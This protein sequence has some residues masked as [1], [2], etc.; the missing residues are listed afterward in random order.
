[1]LFYIGEIIDIISNSNSYGVPVGRYRINDLY[2]CNVHQSGNAY[3]IE[4]VNDFLKWSFAF[5]N[6]EE[7]VFWRKESSV[8]QPVNVN[9]APIQIDTYALEQ[10]MNRIIEELDKKQDKRV[11]ESTPKLPEKVIIDSSDIDMN[12]LL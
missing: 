11:E 10:T 3:E 6:H 8:S 9:V 2:G 5:N 12:L 7:N 4:G 1:M